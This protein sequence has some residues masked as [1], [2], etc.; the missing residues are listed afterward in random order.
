M[1]LEK[2]SDLT[3][4]NSDIKTMQDVLDTITEKYGAFACD[5]WRFAS[6]KTISKNEA[7]YYVKK[8]Y[9]DFNNDTFEKF[10]NLGLECF[11]K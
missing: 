6:S 3:G 2:I 8:M 9:L 5:T 4:I 7:K 11:Q 1:E 10:Y